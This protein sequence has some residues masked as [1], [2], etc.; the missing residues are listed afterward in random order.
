MEL[1]PE[2]MDV[3]PWGCSCHEHKRTPTSKWIEFP[4]NQ[5]VWRMETSLKDAIITQSS[6]QT[7]S[8]EPFLNPTPRPQE[9]NLT[10]SESCFVLPQ[11]GSQLHNPWF[12]IPASHNFWSFWNQMTMMFFYSSVE[13]TQILCFQGYGNF[14]AKVQKITGLVTMLLEKA[15]SSPRSILWR[16]RNN[17]DMNT[18]FAISLTALCLRWIM[19]GR[20]R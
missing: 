16:S 17:L 15:Y 11:E 19:P 10:P 13:N 5:W 3:N 9:E 1:F 2:S 6:P 4:Q 20:H 18:Q 7:P 8:L 12:T 14:K